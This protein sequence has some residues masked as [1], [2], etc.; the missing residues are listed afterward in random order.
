MKINKHAD[1][2]LYRQVQNVLENK[3][4]SK[5]WTTGFKLPSEDELAEQFE[6]SSITVKRAITELVN[7][8]YLFRQRGKGTFVT[9]R[10]KEVEIGTIIKFTPDSKEFPHKLI[11][12]NVEKAD[13]HI[14]GKLGISVDELIVKIKRLKVE[15]D[16]P[17]A[18][19]YTYLPYKI[20]NDISPA[21]LDN[22]LVYA[23]L[24]NKYG[25]SLERAKLYIKPFILNEDE[26]D[27][28]GVEAGT[29]VSEW[30]RISFS[31][32]GQKVE[33]S[34]FYIKQDDHSFYINVS[35]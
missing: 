28:L 3:I 24:K 30:E 9:D 33:Y 6:V 26:A 16:R 29:P 17:L 2:P 4:K 13:P 19:E 14:A 27:L 21:D 8:G 22:Q 1:T 34:K 32:E 12:F 7:R 5:E 15:N 18:I 35:L 31:K 10:S 25:V 23:V 11:S 20:C